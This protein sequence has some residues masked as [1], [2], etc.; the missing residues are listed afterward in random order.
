MADWRNRWL[1]LD[2]VVGSLKP[3]VA[4][5]LVLVPAGIVEAISRE[6][7]HERKY[8]FGFF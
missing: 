7:R 1:S 5:T 2:P 3:L 8:R 4:A 6:K